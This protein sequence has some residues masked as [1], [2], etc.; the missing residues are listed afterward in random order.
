MMTDRPE[1]FFFFEREFSTRWGLAHKMWLV[2]KACQV[3]CVISHDVLDLF[4]FIYFFKFKD[5][6]IFYLFLN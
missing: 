3:K 4:L 1:L 6:Y 5:I 2:L